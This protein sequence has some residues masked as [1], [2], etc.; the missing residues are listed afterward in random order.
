MYKLCNLWM[1]KRVLRWLLTTHE[2]GSGSSSAAACGGA[3]FDQFLTAP[4]PWLRQLWQGLL[5]AWTEWGPTGLPCYYS[6]ASIFLTKIIFAKFWRQWNHKSINCLLS[7]IYEMGPK[8]LHD[9]VVLDIKP[10]L[11]LHEGSLWVSLCWRRV[12]SIWEII[13]TI[14]R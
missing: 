4:W 14:G 6:S 9:F 13:K 1:L 12:V 5:I 3:T 7:C 10:K 2:Q 11:Y 8:H